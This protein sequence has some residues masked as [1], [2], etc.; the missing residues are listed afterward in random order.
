MSSNQKDHTIAPTDDP[1]TT[2]APLSPS[3]LLLLNIGRGIGIHVSLF[4][5]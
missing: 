1:L 5:I 4:S 3:N 2:T